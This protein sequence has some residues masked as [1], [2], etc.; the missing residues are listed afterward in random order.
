MST[1]DGRLAELSAGLGAE[2]DELREELADTLRKCR[3]LESE[4]A[5]RDLRISE[6]WELARRQEVQIAALSSRL[7]WVRNPLQLAS[8]ASRR[9]SG[10]L[11]DLRSHRPDGGA[12]A[13]TSPGEATAVEDGDGPDLRRVA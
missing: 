12:T 13:E 11:A 8:A 5:A 4:V 9:L 3:W 7:R 2:R 10:V 6:L 1:L